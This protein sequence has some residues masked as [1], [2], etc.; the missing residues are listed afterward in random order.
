MP[1]RCY[2]LLCISTLPLRL[3]YLLLFLDVPLFAS[4]G[5]IA[6]RLHRRPRGLP[7][8]FGVTDPVVSG[9]AILGRSIQP[10]SLP[11]WFLCTSTSHFLHPSS[12]HLS[13]VWPASFVALVIP[14]LYHHSASAI[15][16]HTS[17]L[18]I[19]HSLQHTYIPPTTHASRLGQPKL[20][21]NTVQINQPRL[22]LP[23]DFDLVVTLYIAR[24]PLLIFHPWPL[25]FSRI[26]FCRSSGKRIADS[27]CLF[28]LSSCHTDCAV[29][30]PSSTTIDF[31]L[32]QLHGISNH[33]H[34]CRP[35][36]LGYRF[37]P[38]AVL[39]LQ[40][41]RFSV[42]HLLRLFL[43]PGCRHTFRSSGMYARRRTGIRSSKQLT[44]QKP[45]SLY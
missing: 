30:N 22:P 32:P 3:P 38:H 43:L 5:Y 40:S 21:S 13:V 33:N 6:R 27:A 8:T 14:P 29:P 41:L 35:S 10:P 11:L 37:G 23:T 34:L 15:R 26:L 42:S 24:L 7:L 12:T 25:F 1:G 17:T 20:H 9:F 45:L 36:S 19:V 4:V 39:H 31:L 16:A 28:F 2:H 44:N 18:H